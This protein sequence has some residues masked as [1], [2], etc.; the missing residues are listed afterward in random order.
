MRRIEAI[1][2]HASDEAISL[3]GPAT[4]EQLV[5]DR[6]TSSAL[7]FSPDGGKLAFVSARS[8]RTLVGVLDLGS[9]RIA[10]MTPSV[11][12]D[13]APEWSPDSRQIA[14]VRVPAEQGAVDFMPHRTGEPWSIWVANANTGEG[15]AIWTAPP[16]SRQRVSSYGEQP[17]SPV[18]CQWHHRLPLGTYWLAA[19]LRPFCERRSTYATHDRRQLRGFQY[20]AEPRPYARRLFHQ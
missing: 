10:W 20:R 7:A 15:R 12:S 8:G 2:S 16:R 4:P 11:D 14:F 17:R 6:G 3:T 13:M 1:N 5:H 18:G 19:S 9:R